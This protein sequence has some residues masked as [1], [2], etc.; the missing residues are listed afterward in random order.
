MPIQIPIKG[1][2]MDQNNHLSLLS[3]RLSK[4]VFF[5]LLNGITHGAIKVND[6]NSSY[7]FGNEKERDD[8]IA[9]ITINTPKAYKAMLMGG[10]VGAGA[11]YIDGD[12]DTDDLQKLIELIIKNDSLFNNIESPIARLFSFIRTIVPHQHSTFG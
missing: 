3:T 5:K 6:V 12:W 4:K 10:S 9:A 1:H 7:V 11:S 2:R 8:S